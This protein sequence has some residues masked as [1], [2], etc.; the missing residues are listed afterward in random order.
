MKRKMWGSLLLLLPFVGCNSPPSAAAEPAPKDPASTAPVKQGQAGQPNVMPAVQLGSYASCR[1]G[2]QV[3]AAFQR[4]VEFADPN[5]DGA[6]TRAEASSAA[7]F[8]VGGFFFRADENGDGTVTPAEGLQARKDFA[9]GQPLAASLLRQ[10][11]AQTGGKGPL[12]QIAQMLD[13]QYSQPV[14]AE[15]ARGAARSAVD[16]LFAAADSDK[17]QTIT[18]EEASAASWEGARAAG[19]AM[20]RSIDENGDKQLTVAEFRKSLEVPAGVAFK[21]ADRN[22]DGRLTQDE[23]GTAIA[24]VVKQ[25]GVPTAKL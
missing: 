13:I 14:K 19:E 7:N 20:F 4:L 21:A 10:V 2:A 25:L 11:E 12:A 9:A 16:D 1:P 3:S 8:L 18:Q 17:N 23:A 22:S 24:G 6:V 15:Q 5:G